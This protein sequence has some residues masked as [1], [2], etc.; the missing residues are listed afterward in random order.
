MKNIICAFFLQLVVG[1]DLSK[2][3]ENCLSNCQYRHGDCTWCGKDGYCCA[4]HAS[5]CTRQMKE[6]LKNNGL[7]GKHRCVVPSTV[8]KTSQL[9]KPQTRTEFIKYFRSSCDRSL[10][11]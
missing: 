7:Y 5:G 11:Y 2:P 9:Q 4:T 8:Q 10:R 3:S 6:V 1:F